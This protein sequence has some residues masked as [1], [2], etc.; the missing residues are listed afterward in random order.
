M[1]CCAS[2][3]EGT[4]G[5]STITCFPASNAALVKEKWVSGV[6]VIT[7]MSIEGSANVSVAEW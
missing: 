7:M 6:V 3:E 1:S 4:N 2:E 5:F